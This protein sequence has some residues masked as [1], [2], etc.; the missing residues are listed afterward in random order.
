MTQAK[1]QFHVCELT[2]G[3]T[4]ELDGWTSQTDI[5]N[6]GKSSHTYS[7]TS[8]TTRFT[9]EIVSD[10]RKPLVCKVRQ[11]HAIKDEF[12][13]TYYVETDLK[14]NKREQEVFREL[15]HVFGIPHISKILKRENKP[16]K[17]KWFI[18]DFACTNLVKGILFSMCPHYNFNLRK[19]IEYATKQG[20]F[21]ITRCKYSGK[22]KFSG[23]PRNK[24]KLKQ[25]LKRNINRFKAYDKETV[26]Y[27]NGL[28]YVENT[29]ADD[30]S[31]GLA[32]DDGDGGYVD[33]NC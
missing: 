7:D 16:V 27:Q 11:I 13:I 25:F 24:K 28:S 18:N 17:Y 21:Q 26:T 22:F 29:W 31:H 4:V 2:E 23:K 19:V 32:S 10:V 33:Y 14:Y 12:E 6:V 20:M 15:Y 3:S 5:D 1:K 8:I 30:D 9:G